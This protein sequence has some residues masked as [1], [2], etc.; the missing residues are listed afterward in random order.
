MEASTL[1]R[2]AEI[3]MIDERRLFRD[4]WFNPSL[5]LLRGVEARLV[6]SVLDRLDPA[7]ALD[8]GCGSGRFARCLDRIF[9]TGL[10]RDSGKLKAA[11]QGGCF[12]R[13]IC[14]NIEN[15]H[16]SLT[17][18]FDFI[19]LNSVLEHVT[20]PSLALGALS[21]LCAPGGHILLSV[22][23]ERGSRE[24]SPRRSW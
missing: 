11:K 5:A 6:G 20:D 17:A 9:D 2:I 18:R 8:A 15:V 16:H 7:C 21:K 3:S 22:P 10:D 1:S 14:E 19:L 13:L 24:P 4:Y 12:E 23:L